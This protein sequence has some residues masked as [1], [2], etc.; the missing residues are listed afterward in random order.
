MDDSVTHTLGQEQG[1]IPVD[2]VGGKPLVEDPLT[3][4]SRQRTHTPLRNSDNPSTGNFTDIGVISGLF[5]NLGANNPLTNKV[6]ATHE[7]LQEE[8]S[9][10]DN[11]IGT[12]KQK[13]RLPLRSSE[14]F[15][16]L[17]EDTTFS[18]AMDSAEKV[19]VGRVR[20]H[21]YSVERL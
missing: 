14:I 21:H 6:Q 19:P 17:A 11:W 9:A 13:K 3:K 16:K 8:T 15:L 7:A 18:E 12:S 1:S 5:D 10:G 2:T 20:G 4:V